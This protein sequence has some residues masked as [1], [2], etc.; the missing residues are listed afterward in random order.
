MGWR[1][2]QYRIG[3]LRAGISTVDWLASRCVSKAERRQRGGRRQLCICCLL[4]W[5]WEVGSRRQVAP[6]YKRTL[7]CSELKIICTSCRPFFLLQA[8][9]ST[10]LAQVSEALTRA[11]KLSTR[12]RKNNSSCKLFIVYWNCTRTTWHPCGRNIALAQGTMLLCR[13]INHASMQ[14]GSNA[15]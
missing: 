2:S 8:L 7:S 3:Y 6:A 13:M 4:V 5:T 10:Q 9:G 15:S 12:G 11:G 1:Y 14:E